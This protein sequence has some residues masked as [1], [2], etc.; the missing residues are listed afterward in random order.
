MDHDDWL[1]LAEV[2]ALGA[3]EGDELAK[4]EAHLSS[5]CPQCETWLKETG[6]ALVLVPG[7]LQ[8]PTLPPAAKAQI[9]EQIEVNKPGLVFTYSSEGEWQEMAP[10]IQAKILYMD[11]AQ[12]RVT[13]LVRMEPGSRY[14][15]HRH[16]QSEEL[17]VLEGSCYCAGRL[18]RQG[19]YHRAE[20]GSIHLD[21]HTDE[22]SL[23]L[24]ITAIQNEMIT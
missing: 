11:S 9:L 12:Q 2:Y 22:G 21:T 10:G 20:A 5:G 14:D 24:V 4:F 23:M 15:N 17:Y 3:L 8:P 18:L 16:T 6:E 1:E 19:D 7:S 13:A